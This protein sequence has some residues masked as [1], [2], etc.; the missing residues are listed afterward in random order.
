MR[1]L[2]RYVRPPLVAPYSKTQVAEYY[3]KTQQ[4]YC[5]AYEKLIQGLQ[6]SQQAFQTAESLE[7]KKKIATSEL[8]LWRTFVTSRMQDLPTHYQIRKPMQNRLE[9]TWNRIANR[10]TLIPA[11]DFV[12]YFSEFNKHYTG[13]FPFDQVAVDG[14]AHPVK[15]H[16]TRL[17]NTF[18]WQQFLRFLQ[19]ETL[20][21]YERQTGQ[22]LPAKQIS[23]Y[24]LWTVLDTEQAGYLNFQRFQQLLHA[25]HLPPVTTFADLQK[26]FAWTLQD[27]PKELE[28]MS[29][30]KSVLRF[31]LIRRLFLERNA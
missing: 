23:A 8:L 18:H 3:G 14:I 17:P 11:A 13:D 6:S 15:G 27:L 30:S 31:E 12:K 21:S 7:A 22:H 1:A 24:N 26:E 20:A 5:I 2:Q 29:E 25:L 19:N 4:Y 10:R 16:M 9:R 28:G